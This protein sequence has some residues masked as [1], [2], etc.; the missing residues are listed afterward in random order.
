MNPCPIGC[1][2]AL[3][4]GH[5]FNSPKN[6]VDPKEN[7]RRPFEPHSLLIARIDRSNPNLANQS[8]NHEAH[9]AIELGFDFDLGMLIVVEQ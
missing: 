9:A 1:A 2:T 8:I 3:R 4:P 6:L 7:P 5:Q